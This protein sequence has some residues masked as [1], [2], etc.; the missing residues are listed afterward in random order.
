MLQGHGGHP[1]LQHRVQTGQHARLKAQRDQ[2]CMRTF[3]LWDCPL[4]RSSLILFLMHKP[5]MSENKCSGSG[6]HLPLRPSS[7]LHSFP[8]APLLCSHLS[9]RMP[10]F[11]NKSSGQCSFS[12]QA[13][14][15][16]NQLPVCVCLCV[17]VC[18]CAH[19]CAFE[20]LLTKHAHVNFFL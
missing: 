14:T 13:V 4:M 20:P 18:A 5:D 6:P 19:V 7:P 17:C 12:Y 16:R 15:T 2:S 8:A 11:H 9:V 1:L 10:S 3:I